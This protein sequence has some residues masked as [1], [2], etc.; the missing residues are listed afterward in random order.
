[1]GEGAIEG[2]AADYEM[3]SKWATEFKYSRFGKVAA[4][5]RDVSTLTGKKVK[6]VNTVA[7][8]TD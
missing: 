5:P 7:K 1:M 6:R 8:T 2:V 4:P 3:P